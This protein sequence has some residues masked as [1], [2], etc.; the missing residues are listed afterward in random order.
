[1]VRTFKLQTLTGAAQPLF[2]DVLTAA[3]VVPAGFNNPIILKVADTTIWAVGDR[4]VLDPGA[5]DADVVMVDQVVNGTTLWC[6]SEG[7]RKLNPHANG[8][9]IALSMAVSD[10]WVQAVAGGAN[11]IW[12]AADSTVTSAGAGKVIYQ[13]TDSRPPFHSTPGANY[14]IVRTTDFWMAAL[15]T[16]QAIVAANQV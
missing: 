5:T 3:M 13:V 8:T 15:A 9:I 6:Q 7:D 11:P 12:I 16:T 1:M 2:G 10:V 14:N 4:I